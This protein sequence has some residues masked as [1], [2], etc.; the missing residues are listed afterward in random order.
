M[1][2]LVLAGVIIA[3]VAAAAVATGVRDRRRRRTERLAAEAD[4]VPRG[5]PIPGGWPGGGSVES[6]SP[7]P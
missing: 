6:R 4:C 3:A 1:L 7:A 2:E 5:E